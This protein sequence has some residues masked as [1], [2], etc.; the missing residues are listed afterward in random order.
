MP[1][2]KDEWLT[3]ATVYDEDR[4]ALWRRVFDQPED[5]KPE[6]PIVSLIPITV[7]VPDHETPQRAYELD[8][9]A[10]TTRQ[11]MR[12]VKALAEC[13][14]LDPATVEAEIDKVGVPILVRDVVAHTR[15]QAL[16]M[17]MLL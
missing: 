10:I 16:V 7:Q 14:Q 8:L 6:V 5:E 15:D 4:A 1:N 12:L 13:F 17:G 9:N 2:T 11:R 3:T